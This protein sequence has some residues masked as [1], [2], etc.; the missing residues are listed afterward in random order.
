MPFWETKL[1]WY[2]ILTKNEGEVSVLLGEV[3]N[4]GIKTTNDT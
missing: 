2:N 1:W 3:Y 4:L